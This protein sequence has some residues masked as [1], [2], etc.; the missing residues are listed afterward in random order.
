MMEEAMSITPI[1]FALIILLFAF[2]SA[3][4]ATN[5]SGKKSE[6]F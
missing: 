3:G 2:D 4:V 6:I 1:V 5:A